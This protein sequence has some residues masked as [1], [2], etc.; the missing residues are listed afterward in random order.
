MIAYIGKDKY[1]N[2][3]LFRRL[4]KLEEDFSQ[5]DSCMIISE[6]IAKNLLINY[7]LEEYVLEQIKL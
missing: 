3:G 1:G 6:S 7:E 4:E 2:Y 5:M